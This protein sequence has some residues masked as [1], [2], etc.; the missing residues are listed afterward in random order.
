[1]EGKRRR[2]ER[3]LAADPDLNVDAVA[4]VV[5]CSPTTVKH[6]RKKLGPPRRV[7]KV[8]RCEAVLRVEPGANL[9]EVAEAVGCSY[10]T[11]YSAATRLGINRDRR[12]GS[13]VGQHRRWH[14]GRGRADPECELCREG[15]HQAR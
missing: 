9:D 5:G 12:H 11:A 13:R 14:V 8:E 1:V 6:A 3:L 2:A 10:G 15:V 7:T 4:R